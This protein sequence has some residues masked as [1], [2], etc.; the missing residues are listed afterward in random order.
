MIYC[1]LLPKWV[2]EDPSWDRH[3]LPRSYEGEYSEEEMLDLNQ[4]GY[5]AYFHVNYPDQYNRDRFVEAADVTNF[6]SVFVDLDMKDYLS[7]VP[8]RRHE[9]A[10]KE[11]FMR[12]LLAFK[13][14]PSRIVDSGNGV[15]AYWYLSDLT[16]LDF[17]RFQ[18]RLCRKFKTDPAVSK[19]KQI[20]RV[21]GTVNWKDP[22]DPKLAELVTDD[23]YEYTA[24]QL[25]A[26]LPRISDKDEA[27]CKAHYD[28]AHGLEQKLDVSDELPAVWFKLAKPGTEPHR[29]FYGQVKDRSIADFR[30]GHL[31]LAAGFTKIEAMA[32]LMNTSKASERAGSHRY[33][34]A[35]GVVSKVW[36]HVAETAKDQV[37]QA[38]RV[39][40]V[41]ELLE[42]NPNG[43]EHEGQ[44]LPC[45]PYIDGTEK[46]T[47][48]GQILGLIAGSGV[49]KT[50]FGLNIFLGFAMRNP[51][52]NIVFLM[53][54]LEQPER[55]YVARWAKMCQGNDAL[56][57]RIYVLGNYN[58]DGTYRHLSLPEI[59]DEAKELMRVTGKEIGATMIDHIGV[60]KKENR[61]GE[62]Q[63][64]IDVCQYMKAFAVNLNTFLI[65][66]SQAPREKASIGDIELDKDA[67]YGTVFFESFCDYVVTLWQ[68]LKRLY[69]EIPNLTVTVFKFCKIRDK[70]VIK[71]RIKED[72]RY[73][74]ILDPDTELMRQL[75]A[76]EQKALDFNAGRATKLR[77][78][79][80]KTEPGRISVINWGDQA[81]KGGT[82]GN[83]K[84]GK[85]APL[86]RPKP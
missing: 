55:E 53:V 69:D 23:A 19:L 65:M 48:R 76:T 39:R 60:L 24:E 36:L 42:M 74:L 73:P 4:Q 49:G 11:D 2:E 30:L 54:S 17:L 71:D 66:Q 83:V 80:K 41:R 52:P 38:G 84:P 63:G 10:T 47:R 22:N 14:P 28:K 8:D 58:D 26:A 12:E 5:N 33:N 57:N 79:D 18:R 6:N 40:S 7:E 85:T 29:L 56:I 35:D 78:R 82:D 77:A 72:Q 51:D 61:N 44:R 9:W 25:N 45:H 62:N 1:M 68:P 50:A 31:M 16:D 81:P 67:A 70:H 15:H 64:L 3:K 20:M 27:Y 13:L 37:K 46:G 43:D 75:T 34:Y 32:V 59:E 21:P 86:S